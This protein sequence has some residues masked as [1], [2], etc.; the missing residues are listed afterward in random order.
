M[1][2]IFDCD[3]S[4]LIGDIESRKWEHIDINQY[5]GLTFKAISELHTA[6]KKGITHFAGIQLISA[7]IQDIDFQVI[8]QELYAITELSQRLIQSAIDGN[9]IIDGR[10][11]YTEDGRVI[12]PPKE[13]REYKKEQIVRMLSEKLRDEI[14]LIVSNH[15]I[16]LYEDEIKKA[17]SGSSNTES[18]HNGQ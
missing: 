3:I 11:D 7:L 4:Y 6:Y 14:D 1:S 18:D 5:T 16:L 9:D 13:T 8:S 10:L 15:L 17:A 2:S 12:L